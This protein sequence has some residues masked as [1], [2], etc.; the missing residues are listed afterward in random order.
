[1]HHFPNLCRIRSLTTDS[2]GCGAKTGGVRGVRAVKI[3]L[4]QPH[5]DETIYHIVTAVEHRQ[6]NDRYWPN[7]RPRPY[8]SFQAETVAPS[9]VSANHVAATGDAMPKILGGPK[10]PYNGDILLTN[11]AINT[12]IL[13]I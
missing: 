7:S 3:S 8:T 11:K 2:W 12:E 9:C 6:P 5:K 13:N 1:M 10:P 4:F